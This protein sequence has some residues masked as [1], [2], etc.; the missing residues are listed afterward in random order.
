[1][2]EPTGKP[3]PSIFQPIQPERTP[4][5]DF[6]PKNSKTRSES[7]LDESG[8]SDARRPRRGGHCIGHLVLARFPQRAVFRASRAQ[9]LGPFPKQNP[10]LLGE[11]PSPAI[12]SEP[13]LFFLGSFR[14]ASIQRHPSKLTEFEWWIE[15]GSLKIFALMGPNSCNP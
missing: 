2:I 12:G 9:R 5:L 11:S 6:H 10:P 15:N 4:M 1:M 14:V 3:G 8:R 7:R 13:L